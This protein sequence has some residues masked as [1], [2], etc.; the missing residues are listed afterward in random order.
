MVSCLWLPCLVA[1]GMLVSRSFV[2]LDLLYLRLPKISVNTFSY[3]RTK[4]LL[5]DHMSHWEKT[6][7][8]ADLS[9]LGNSPPR[10]KISCLPMVMVGWGEHG[11]VLH[12]V[13]MESAVAWEVTPCETVFLNQPVSILRVLSFLC[14]VFGLFSLKLCC[15]VR[16]P[17]AVCDQSASVCAM[18]ELPTGFWILKWKEESKICF[19]NF[20][21][22][23]F[24]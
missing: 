11:M 20:Y 21:I 2:S 15:P 23:M 3:L 7:R 12:P 13:S 14:C 10:E 6:L 8:S 18:C 24:K 4:N 5:L 22:S 16:Q 17:R 19:N 9:F 1:L